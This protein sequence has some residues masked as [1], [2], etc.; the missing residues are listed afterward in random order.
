MV[1]WFLVSLGVLSAKIIT[2]SGT[3]EV[4]RIFLRPRLAHCKKSGSFNMRVHV[5]HVKISAGTAQLRQTCM[6]R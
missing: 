1:M 6:I 4:L 3:N 5:Y 2:G